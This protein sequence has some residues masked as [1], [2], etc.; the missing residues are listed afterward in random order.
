MNSQNVDSAT[1]K[2]AIPSPSK[3][4]RGVNGMNSEGSPEVDLD[5]LLDYRPVP[6]R[7]VV[8]MSVRYRQLGRGRPLPYPLEEDNEG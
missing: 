5:E 3:R 6:P 7:R 2:R 8:T 1:R 4:D